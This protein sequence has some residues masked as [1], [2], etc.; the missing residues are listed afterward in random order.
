M[1]ESTR[2]EGDAPPSVS[3]AGLKR[4]L[5]FF[6][7][8]SHSSPHSPYLAFFLIRSLPSQV[9]SPPFILS[10]PHTMLASIHEKVSSLVHRHRET[11]SKV[12]DPALVQEVVENVNPSKNWD[13]TITFK[14]AEV[15]LRRWQPTL[16]ACIDFLGVYTN[17]YK[18]PVTRISPAAISSL[19]ILSLR[20]ISALPRTPRPWLLCRSSVPVHATVSTM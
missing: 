15:R 9:P 8:L 16:T 12:I 3:N 18:R 13:Y 7:P 17:N 11:I 19:Q 5:L 2:K 6:P 20:P 4:A 14:G 1:Q 10:S